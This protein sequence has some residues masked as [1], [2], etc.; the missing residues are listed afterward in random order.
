MDSDVAGWDVDSSGDFSVGEEL[1]QGR[2][3][4]ECGY[5]ESG[6]VGD[7]GNKEEFAMWSMRA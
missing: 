3:V 4:G 6:I 2:L 1:F 7:H 5:L